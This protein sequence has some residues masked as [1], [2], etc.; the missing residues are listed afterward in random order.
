M[1]LAFVALLE[2]S[3]SGRRPSLEAMTA[4]TDAGVDADAMGAVQVVHYCAAMNA[5][6]EDDPCLFPQFNTVYGRSV[7]L[8]TGMH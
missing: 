2:R 8:G 4:C 6:V 3:S 1:T 5:K 7:L